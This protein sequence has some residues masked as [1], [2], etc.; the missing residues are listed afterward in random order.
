MSEQ[1]TLASEDN[2]A[3]TNAGDQSNEESKSVA[4]LLNTETDPTMLED[5]EMPTYISMSGSSRRDDSNVSCANQEERMPV[6][7]DNSRSP[8]PSD[9]QG[10]GSVYVLS[11]GEEEDSDDHTYPPEED[12]DY[13]GSEDID[14]MDMENVR[15][16]VLM[17]ADDD[18]DEEDEDDETVLRLQNDE[19]EDYELECCERAS[20]DFIL[21]KRL[22]PHHRK[23]TR[24]LQDLSV[25]ENNM[26]SPYNRKR[27]SIHAFRPNYFGLQQ[28]PE[29]HPVTHRKQS[30]PLRYQ[31]VES[32]VKRYIKDIK[33][34]N[35]R[36]MEKRIKEYATGKN[37]MEAEDTQELKPMIISKTIKDY[38]E[39][40][41]KDLQLEENSKD[42]NSIY[43]AAAGIVENGEIAK[44]DLKL[45]ENQYKHIQRDVEMENY[46]DDVENENYVQK[47]DSKL[48]KRNGSVNAHAQYHSPS[49]RS[50]FNNANEP[51]L[52]N[53]HQQ[54]PT[55]LN[56]RTLSYEEYMHGTSNTGQKEDPA[57]RSHKMEGENHEITEYADAEIIN[58]PEIDQGDPSYHLKIENVKSIRLPSDDSSN[59]AKVNQLDRKNTDNAEVILLQTQINQKTAQINTLRDA[60]QR[61]LSENLKMKQE[62]DALKKSLAKYE[63]QN[64]SDER[65]V[66]AVQTEDVE[67]AVNQKAVADAMRTDN[68]ISTSSV[69]S[70]LSSVDVW[71]DSACSPAISIKPPDLTTVLNSDD[72]MV[73]TNGT[74]RKTLRPL[75]R[76][77]IT[78]SRILQTLSSITQGKAKAESPL[79]QSSKKRSS[80]NSADEL[81]NLDD[82]S[83][84]YAS[85]S[86]KRK[87][88]EMLGTSTYVQPFKIPHTATESERTENASGNE[89]KYPEEPGKIK[90]EEQ[91]NPVDADASQTENS[92]CAEG[93]AEENDDQDGSVKCFV[94]RDDENCKNQ[95]FLIQAEEPTKDQPS[96]G[97]GRIQ[98]CGPYLLGNLEVRMS[99]INGTI[100]IWGKE[101]SQESTNENEEDMEL[102]FK[103]A[104]KKSCHCWQKA[105]QARFNG[106]PIVCSSNK[107]LKIPTRHS[108]ASVSQCSHSSSPNVGKTSFVLNHLSDKRQT[109]SPLTLD[110]C[111][112]PCEDCDSSK[113]RK[114]WPACKRISNSHEK[115]HS[116]SKYRAEF[117]DRESNCSCQERQNREESPNRSKEKFSFKGFRRNY[118]KNATDSCKHVNENCTNSTD[119]S[120]GV[121]AQNEA[122][123]HYSLQSALESLQQNSKC[124]NAVREGTCACKLSSANTSC[125]DSTDRRT[126]NHSPFND[127][128]EDPL[129]PAKRSTETL[130]TRQRRSGRRV[131]G[132][133]MD[134]LRGCGDCRT[135]NTSVNSKTTP[136]GKEAPYSPN[137]APQIKVTPCATSEPSC[138][139][140]P[141]TGNR[142]C[143]A[144]AS[145]IETQLEELRTEM[146]RMRSRSD[147]IVNMLNVLHSVD[148]N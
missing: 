6:E 12:D 80:E 114:D 51:G 128:D 147:A 132:I 133:L 78:S 99:E 64:N 127:D 4:C 2:E 68:K 148:M 58:V 27:N 125:Q 10:G 7:E 120:D 106:S 123:C 55:L 97:K 105:Q 49:D 23:R 113:C 77:F 104:D 46:C 54:T 20:D 76:A 35:R 53:G 66:A 115:I 116:C 129:I 83:P 141:Q 84:I 72:S 11:S 90:L 91:E 24:S 144:Y 89:F 43:N 69:A 110:A 134:L 102:S 33:D 79:A 108:G 146:E 86:K 126:C 26:R 36:S 93:K 139:H 40:V 107:K 70:T 21:N 140:P 75:S 103:E 29:I 25:T 38:A 92:S 19:Y 73:L 17:D 9:D 85:S 44:I 122:Q 109:S 131:R 63:Q 71:A 117:T 145:R 60:Y 8:Y 37:H 137:G 15:S 96:N 74:P 94:Y 42:G 138:S 22:K 61:T 124:C 62:L 143:H 59:F 87:A 50:R 95:S 119:F 88:T 52:L 101:V 81:L 118:R 14:D 16:R 39:K 82:N 48:E 121:C 112:S 57:K 13:E 5:E 100:S 1:T 142:C 56:L 30:L 136:R 130:E 98:E 135:T 45:T 65:K 67:P 3:E 34:Q 111:G 32:K 41:I 18:E 31:H 47:P 28:D